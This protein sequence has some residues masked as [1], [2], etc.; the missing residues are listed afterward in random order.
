MKPAKCVPVHQHHIYLGILCAGSC[1]AALPNYEPQSSPST[2]RGWLRGQAA[3]RQRL[4]QLLLIHLAHRVPRQRIHP[5]PPLGHLHTCHVM[6]CTHAICHV[7]THGVWCAVR[8]HIRYV[9]NN[10]PVSTSRPVRPGQAIA[11]S[12]LR[13]LRLHARACVPGMPPAYHGT[14]V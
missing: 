13:P 8:Q 10:T 4:D 12:M 6:S 14:C 2:T 5:P 3:I 9:H 1:T 11:L 7:M